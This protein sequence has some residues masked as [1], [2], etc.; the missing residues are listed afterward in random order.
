MVLKGWALGNWAETGLE[1]PLFSQPGGLALPWTPYNQQSPRTD[2]GFP[3]HTAALTTTWLFRQT[4]EIFG[5]GPLTS[6]SRLWPLSLLLLPL[7]TQGESEA[8][9]P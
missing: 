3:E 8:Q 9:R 1:P 7:Q 2:T 4:I 6:E 5:L